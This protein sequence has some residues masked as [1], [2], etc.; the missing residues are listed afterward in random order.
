ME[1][2]LGG[3]IKKLRTDLGYTQKEFA[4][5]IGVPQPSLS[6]YE[7]D[8]NLP[9]S[10]VLIKLAH[11]CGISLD[12][13]C[14]IGETKNTGSTPSIDTIVDSLLA[15]TLANEYCI[16]GTLSSPEKVE[17]HALSINLDITAQDKVHYNALLNAITTLQTLSVQYNCFADKD[18]VNLRISK[19]KEQLKSIEISRIVPT[20]ES[21]A[22]SLQRESERAFKDSEK[23][24][25][26]EDG[27]F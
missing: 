12:W 26:V 9:A 3:R 19:L 21:M 1:F 8:K 6:A 11:K 25:K 14:G 20:A 7:N 27:R 2:S 4:E 22:A 10:D 18:Y 15:L 13:L 16:K 17:T 5:L 24:A 23:C